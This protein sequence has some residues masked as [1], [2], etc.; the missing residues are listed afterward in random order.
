MHIKK[1][2]F[3][4]Y[5]FVFAFFFG[6]NAQILEPVKWHFSINNIDES[7]AEITVK[8]T[9]DDGWH[10]YSPSMSADGPFP[11]SITFP[12]IK[13]AKLSGTLQMKSKEHQEYDDIFQMTLKWFEKEA[14][15]VQK[16]L[17]TGKGEVKV[18][19]SVRYSAC[20]EGSC[21]PPVTEEFELKTTSNFIPA[22]GNGDEESVVISP[23]EIK[24]VDFENIDTNVESVVEQ[25]AT[26]SNLWTPVIEELKAFGEDNTK[27]FSLWL[28][29]IGG[30]LGGLI[31]L[32][33]PCVWP[34][35]PMTVSF[36]LKRTKNKTRARKDAVLY[37]LAIV[38]IYVTLGLIITLLFGASALNSLATTAGFNIF[39]FLLLVVL[40]ISFFG[41]FEIRLPASWSN[42]MDSKA[43][44]TA[45]FLSILFM[46][47]TLVLVSFSCT[48]PIIGF[49]LVEISTTGSIIAPLMGMFGFALALAIPFGFFAFF[50]SMLKSLPK[51]GGWLNSVKVT[52]A[53]IELA[54][55][56]KFLSVADLAYHW[57][58]LDREVFLALWIVIFALLGFYLLGKIRFPH[59]SEKKHTSVF[60]TF[61][62]IISLSFAVYMVPGLWGAPLKAISA[63]S[64]PMSTQDF[65]LYNK[66][67]HPKFTDYEEGMAFAAKNNMPVVV[68]FTGWGCINCRNM[69]ASVW[70]DPRV[71]HSLENDFV[72]ISLYVDDK[73]ALREPYRVESNG[74]TIKINTIGDKW[75]YLQSSKFNYNAQP[76]YVILNSAG[77]PLNKSYTYDKSPENFLNWLRTGKENSIKRVKN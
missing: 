38:I 36:F 76:F 4:F 11:T 17:F 37:G 35:I 39:I 58:I 73:T 20:N 19:A 56:L 40:A 25:I 3:V 42:K 77:S 28:I 67:V 70:I 60:G 16:I 50:P 72:L 69:E 21:L 22:K 27:D 74:K 53:F 59:D 62:A 13:H 68:D 47:F 65:N 75:S 2:L 71:K 34:V 66:E 55:A 14:V 51:S 63:F 43:E 23:V 10:I 49:L 6:V 46:A 29:F 57:G 41:A 15:F 5:F 33:T 31:A 12:E 9:I 30:F 44:S 64:P 48:G 52:L 54:L 61:L 32:V 8:A 45:G 26:N 18:L 1:V 7:S 24:V